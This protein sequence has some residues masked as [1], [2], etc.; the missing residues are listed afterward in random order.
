[1]IF[2]TQKNS[3]HHKISYQNLWKEVIENISPEISEFL[4]KSPFL[5]GFTITIGGVS[6]Q[7]SLLE[8]C[9]I[10]WTGR[11]SRKY[12]PK[13]LTARPWKNDS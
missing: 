11:P 9:K 3:T 1:M 8:N 6:I 7:I 12:T 4:V 2:Q 13:N 5:L 10:K